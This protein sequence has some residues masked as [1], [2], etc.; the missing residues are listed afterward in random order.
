MSRVGWTIRRE[1]VPIRNKVAS[2]SI[3]PRGPMLQD[4]VYIYLTEKVSLLG[5]EYLYKSNTF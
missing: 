4:D 2:L 1:G 3:G 5:N